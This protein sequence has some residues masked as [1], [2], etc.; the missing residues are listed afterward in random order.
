MKKLAIIPLLLLMLMALQ[1]CKKEM[2]TGYAKIEKLEMPNTMVATIG[3]DSIEFD[4]RE[5]NFTSGAVMVGDSVKISFV[6][7]LGDKKGKAAVVMLLPQKRNVV[8][9]GYNP[10]AELKTKSATPEEKK[11]FDEFVEKAKESRK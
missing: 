10:D 4:I 9:A 2:Q 7:N 11:S 5:A 6:G 8:E 1:S 3:K